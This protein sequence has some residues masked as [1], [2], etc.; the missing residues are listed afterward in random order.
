MTEE[1]LVAE[2]QKFN[3]P[4]AT[5]IQPATGEDD[6]RTAEELRKAQEKEYGQYV[7]AE[8]I[9]INGVPAFQPGHAVPAGHVSDDGPVLPS[10]V[11]RRTPTVEKKVAEQQAGAE[12]G[13]A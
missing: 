8:L 4:F 11:M 1:P 9:L 7:A 12:P 5:E 6:P 13:K 2:S 3:T 10:Q